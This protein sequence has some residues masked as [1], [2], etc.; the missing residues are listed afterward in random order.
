[1]GWTVRVLGFDSWQGLGVFLFNTASRMALR[2]T[3]PPIQWVPRALFLGVKWLGREADHS[4]QSR[5]GGQ[6]MSGAIPPLPQ[7]AFMVW[8]SVKEI[9]G[10]TLPFT[11]ASLL[12]DKVAP[13][14]I[15]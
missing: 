4:P 11:P 13:M 2:P 12:L 5:A 8:C 10:R 3:Q 9:T 15:S 1:M 6:R 14:P 7:Y